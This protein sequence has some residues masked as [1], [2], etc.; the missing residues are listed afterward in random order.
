MANK[1]AQYP[2]VLDWILGLMA[3]PWALRGSRKKCFSGLNPPERERERERLVPSGSSFGIGSDSAVGLA[4]LAGTPGRD[5]G[6]LTLTT[7][8]HGARIVSVF[9]WIIF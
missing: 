3:V 8:F 5:G 6:W 1:R 9:L 2:I 7:D 4:V